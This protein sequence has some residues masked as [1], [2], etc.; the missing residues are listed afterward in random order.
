MP[1]LVKAV[2]LAQAVRQAKNAAYAVPNQVREVVKAKNKQTAPVA[3]SA[4]WFDDI[5]KKLG[6]YLPVL[7]MP[8]NPLA[9]FARKPITSLSDPKNDPDWG[10]WIKWV[11]VGLVALAAIVVIPRLIPK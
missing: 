9:F 8:G 10:E 4:G 1:Q 7:A 5:K 3:P 11:V 2:D 6:D